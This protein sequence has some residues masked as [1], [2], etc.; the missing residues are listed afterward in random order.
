[1]RGWRRAAAGSQRGRGGSHVIRGGAQLL[2]YAPP[3][4]R[5]V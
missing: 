1:M 5:P 4:A 2:S 3:L